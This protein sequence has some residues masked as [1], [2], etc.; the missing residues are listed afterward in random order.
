MFKDLV[1]SLIKDV[2]ASCP[3]FSNDGSRNLEATMPHVISTET[4]M[5]VQ[6]IIL[7]VDQKDSLIVLLRFRGMPSSDENHDVHLGP[8]PVITLFCATFPPYDTTGTP[9]HTLP[10]I[11]AYKHTH[12]HAHSTTTTATSEE[13][14]HTQDEANL[15]GRE[16]GRSI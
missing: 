2:L 7:L 12:G 5:A 16:G 10:N 11:E 9:T 3:K 8:P 6:S 15:R 14:H 4:A 1:D 13:T